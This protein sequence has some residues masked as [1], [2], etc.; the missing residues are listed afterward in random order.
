MGHMLGHMLGK[1][2]VVTPDGTYVVVFFSVCDLLRFVFSKNQKIHETQHVQE[3]TRYRTYK[4]WVG[5][6]MH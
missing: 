6:Y 3:N 2:R 1:I 5:V 4:M